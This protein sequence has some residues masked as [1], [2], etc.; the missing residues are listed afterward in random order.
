[1]LHYPAN[2]C[3]KSTKDVVGEKWC[4][5]SNELKCLRKVGHSGPHLV[6]NG[7]PIHTLILWDIKD[8]GEV[9]SRPISKTKWAIR[10]L[11]GDDAA[12]KSPEPD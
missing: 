1:M 10:Y 9:K 11:F 3:L 7:D 8:T 6:Q 4:G 12:E 5:F 2:R